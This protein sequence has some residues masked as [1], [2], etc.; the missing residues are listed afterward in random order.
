MV[1]PRKELPFL[2]CEFGPSSRVNC[3]ARPQ[4]GVF[5]PVAYLRFGRC[6]H[7]PFRPCPNRRDLR[8]G[9]PPAS[10]ARAREAVGASSPPPYWGGGGRETAAPGPCACWRM[11][12]GATAGVRPSNASQQQNV[13]G[14]VVALCTQRAPTPLQKSNL[15]SIAL[16]CSAVL[17]PPVFPVL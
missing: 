5:I 14:L 8:S 10:R 11:H 2:F 13:V 16:L 12:E 9:R 1:D 17:V 3:V 15:H 6:H 4:N 7:C